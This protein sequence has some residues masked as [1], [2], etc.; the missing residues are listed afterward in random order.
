MGSAWGPCLPLPVGASKF[1]PITHSS[2]YLGLWVIRLRHKE[3]VTRSHSQT[4]ADH[5]KCL[6]GNRRPGQSQGFLCLC[7]AQGS[8]L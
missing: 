6:A 2:P 7:R 4:T 3:P 5:G 1:S 8:D